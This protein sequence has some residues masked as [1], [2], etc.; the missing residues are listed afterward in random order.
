MPDIKKIY[1]PSDMGSFRRKRNDESVTIVVTA[2][3][4]WCYSDPNN[5]FANGFLAGG[6]YTATHPNTEYGPYTPVN[7]GTVYYNAVTTGTCNPQGDA[8]TGHTITVSN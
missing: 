6:S 7:A 2:D 3:C 8:A 1:L 4:T 5:C